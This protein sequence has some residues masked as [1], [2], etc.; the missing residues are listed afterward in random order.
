MQNGGGGHKDQVRYS[1]CLAQIDK[2]GK[3]GSNNSKCRVWNFLCYLLASCI[4]FPAL[5]GGKP[6]SGNTPKFTQFSTI[7]VTYKQENGRNI[8]NFAI[9]A[10]L[11]VFWSQIYD[12]TLLMQSPNVV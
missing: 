5:S 11:R 7:S 3:V 10:Q 6:N 1:P 9:A 4:L 8:E 2:C 12:L